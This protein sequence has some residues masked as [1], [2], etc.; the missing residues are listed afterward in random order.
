MSAVSENKSPLFRYT[1][2]NGFGVQSNGSEIILFF[3][4]KE[5]PQN[6]KQ[7]FLKEVGVIMLPSTMKVLAKTLNGL[8]ALFERAAGAEIAVDQNRLDEIEKQLT[9]AFNVALPTASQPLS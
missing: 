4:V 8:V 3:G 5:D 6:P 1:F 2:C 9:S 7:D